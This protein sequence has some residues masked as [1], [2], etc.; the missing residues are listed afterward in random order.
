[1]P[2]RSS[3]CSR[4]ASRPWRSSSCYG[5]RRSR[6]A[7]RDPRGNGV[8]QG[9]VHEMGDHRITRRGLVGAAATGAAGIALTRTAGAEAAGT[10]RTADVAIVGAGLA[11]LTAARRLVAA[12][13]S[14]VVLEARDRVG[15][16]V[17]SESIGGGEI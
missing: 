7:R 9:Y 8:V 10:T 15:G 5:S 1:M 6:C 17:L 11:G 4:P 16:R 2:C 14:V 13:R 3:S 12:G